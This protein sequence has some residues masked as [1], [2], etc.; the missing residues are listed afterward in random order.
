NTGA[1]SIPHMCISTLAYPLICGWIFK[2]LPPLGYCEHEHC[3]HLCG[4][5]ASAPVF[6]SSG[7]WH[8]PLFWVFLNQS[9]IK[10]TP[11]NVPSGQPDPD[12]SSVVTLPQVL[13]AVSSCQLK[14]TLLDL[15]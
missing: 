9:T 13:Y 4:V 7:E 11:M 12:S 1:S 14:L 10:T 5:M 8:H 2:L 15:R 6:N 3:E